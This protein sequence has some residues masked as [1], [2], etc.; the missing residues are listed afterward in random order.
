MRRRG[1]SSV[2]ASPLIV[3][4]VTLLVV[5]VATVLAWFANQ[6]LPFVPTRQIRFEVS[7]GANLLPG[8]EVRVGGFRIGI[9]DDMKPVPMRDGSVGALVT[10]KIDKKSQD[11]TEDTTVAIRPRSVLGLKY[12][13]IHR[14]NGRVLNAGDTLP[15]EQARFP[16]ELDELYGIFDEET[17]TGSRRN[18][19]GFGDAFAQRGPS[20]NRTIEEAPRFLRHLEPVMRVLGEPGTHLER[21]FGELGDFTRIVA[22]VAD[23]YAHGFSAGADTFEAWSRDAAALKETIEKSP[24]VLDAGIRSMRVQRPFLVSLRDF[25]VALDDAAQQ[26]PRTL[27]RI[28]PALDAGIPVLR[29]SPQANV[30]LEKTLRTLEDLMRSPG[31][32]QSFRGLGGTVNTLNPTL[33][34]LGPYITVCNYFNYAWTHAAEHLSEPDPT[35]GSQRT[36]LN[37]AG[38]QFDPGQPGQRTGITTLGAAYPANGG[39]TQ[40]NSTPQFLHSNNYSAAVSRTGEADCE[41]G[42]RGYIERANAYAPP[43]VKTVVDPHIPGNQGPTFT[44]LTKV[45]Q[46]QTF[47][48]APE[49][50]PQFPKELDP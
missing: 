15:A 22:P 25:S 12:V 46:G 2:F 49:A 21:F 33:R 41:S 32:G 4:A 42:Q 23:R 43:E 9:V 30:E 24:P 37:Q 50:G 8:N 11:I 7:N 44:G 1:G 16:V 39:I 27:P 26:L 40:P 35:G 17:R 13:E 3:G 19:R 47:S 10:L 5:N 6:G 38:Q 45:P 18:L 36:L 14:G 34:F 20:L 29:R 48:R 31:T 28:I